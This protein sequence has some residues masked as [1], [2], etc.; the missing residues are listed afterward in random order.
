MQRPAV[1]LSMPAFVDLTRSCIDDLGPVFKTGNEVFMYP[2]NGHGAWEA[3][4]VNV[5][6]PGDRVLAPETGMFSAAWG[7][8]AQALGMLIE[9]QPGDWRHGIDP[10]RLEER[11]RAD[12]R[13]TIKAVLAV[14]TDTATG[15]TSDIAAT[16]EAMDRA[17]HPA[18]LLV[19][20]I[21][22]LAATD[23]R[24]DEW[25]I[26]V[27]VG[28]SQKALMSPPGLSFSAVSEKAL[29]ASARAGAKRY[30]WD[31]D[32]RRTPQWYDWFCGT[33]P[34]HM[35]F[36][37]RESLDMLAEEGLDN[38]LDR[39]RR[40]ADGVRTA[41][42]CWARNGALEFNALDATEQSNAVSTVRVNK[43][44]DAAEIQRECRDRFN[45]SL[46][47]GLGRLNGKAFRIGHMGNINEAMLL[48]ALGG[49]EA[50]FT[51]CAVPYETGVGA[52]IAS[53]AVDPGTAGAGEFAPNGAVASGQ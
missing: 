10:N 9:H 49:V 24:V 18:L 41:I 17:R 11:L 13:S 39:H 22:S 28:A 40:L 52:A 23:L 27:A 53:Y 36:A 33:A 45:V 44:H 2:A 31:W 20:A 42:R 12:T 32:K 51:A 4:L 8:M 5:L 26:D 6:S 38:A 50:T 16:R 19:D 25:R 14:H 15:I 29:A 3:A 30:Y 1:E 34:E 47:G 43:P 48:G 37:L 21:A 46:A 7:R 35:L